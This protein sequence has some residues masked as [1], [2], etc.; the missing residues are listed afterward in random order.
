MLVFELKSSAPK[1]R[2]G[3]FC[4][5]TISYNNIEIIDVIVIRFEFIA[6]YSFPISEEWNQH[7]FPLSLN[8]F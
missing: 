6:K 7:I 2:L 4:V 3:L 5:H 1:F 8:I